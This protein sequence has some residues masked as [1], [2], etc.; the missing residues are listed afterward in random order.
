MPSNKVVLIAGLTGSGK[1]TQVNM[2]A[3]ALRLKAVHTSE[4]MRKMNNLESESN[5]YWENEGQ[6]FLDRRIGNPDIDRKLDRELLQTLEKENCIMDSWTM[7]WLYKGN[8]VRVWL[9]ASE[10]ARA[11]RVA[12]RSKI[13]PEDAM[14][15]N[16]NRDEKTSRI[17]FQLYAIKFG[18]DLGPF[19]IVLDTEHL[20][21]NQVFEALEPAARILLKAKK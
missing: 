14:A 17:Y 15:K 2:L 12:K 19:D 11:E 20:N 3:E 6:V 13:T 16:R 8:A 5:A 7:P 10:N 21:E 4:L 1:T 9:K 18:E